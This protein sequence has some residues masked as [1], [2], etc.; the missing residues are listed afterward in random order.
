M[1]NLKDAM[2]YLVNM[3]VPHTIDMIG[4]RGETV[5]FVD[6][7]MRQ[8]MP[9][10]NIPRVSNEDEIRMS[11]L[12]S[13]VEYLKANIDVEQGAMILHVVSP[14]EVRYYSALNE[15]RERERLVRVIA[16]VPD[17]SF[18]RFMD[19][20]NFVISLQSKFIPGEDRDLLLKFAGTVEDG[21]V[22]TYGDDGVTQKAT[23][24]TGLASKSDALVPNPV[25]LRPYRTFIE[26]TQPESQFIFRMKQDKYDGVSC[27]IFEAD[28]GAWVNEAMHNIKEYLKFE[29]EGLDNITV[30]S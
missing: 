6:K 17:F 14:T 10:S 8:L 3:A 21:T 7:T 13:L 4:N 5:T 19:Q 16:N 15:N 11:T 26:V 2:E 27:A 30:I 29:L 20:E 28:G 12:T 23:I 25:H 9:K 18:G 1:Y 22:Q 24:K